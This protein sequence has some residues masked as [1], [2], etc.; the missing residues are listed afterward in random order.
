M[1]RWKVSSNVIEDYK[2]YEVYR[3]INDKEVDHSGNREYA[4]FFNN[5]AEALREAEKLNY[6]EENTSP[7]TVRQMT[8]AERERYFGKE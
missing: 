5:R 1:G 7:C 2:T 3:V 8:S 4:G 6:I